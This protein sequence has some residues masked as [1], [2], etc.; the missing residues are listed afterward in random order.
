MIKEILKKLDKV[1]NQLPY[2]T[3]VSDG[4]KERINATFYFDKRNGKGYL[5]VIFGSL[6]I[7]PPGC[8]HGGAIAS[9]IDEAMGGTVW[10]NGYTVMT[11][12]LEITYL[13]PVP[14]TTL[15]LGEFFLVKVQNKI[16]EIV[17]KLISE[18]EKIEYA[19]SRGVFVVVD[20][21]KLKNKAVIEF[22]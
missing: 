17:G 11:A 8:A 20:Y 16:I 5:E 6:C 15:I 9:V 10:L 22:E 2:N 19:K 18:D 1:D 14:L 7:G 4:N 3:Y 21:N 12:K 13:N